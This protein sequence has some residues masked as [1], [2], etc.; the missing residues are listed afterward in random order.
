MKKIELGGKLGGNGLEERKGINRTERKGGWM[1]RETEE[2]KKRRQKLA[3]R[4]YVGQKNGQEK[5]GEGIRRE[6][7]EGR[8][9]WEQKRKNGA[10]GEGSEIM[11]AQEK[12][13]KRNVGE[14]REIG[15]ETGKKCEKA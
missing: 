15:I 14:K 2:E 6:R 5:L 11:G 4:K 1:R 12:K 13:S 8:K 3:L 10:G 7:R 9:R